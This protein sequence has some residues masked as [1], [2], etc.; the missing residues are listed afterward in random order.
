[1]QFAGKEILPFSIIPDPEEKLY[2]LYG[3]QRSILGK[4]KTMLQ[5]GK[6]KEIMS[7]G[8][9]NLQSMTKPNTLPADFLIDE[10]GQIIEA[11]YGKDFGD[12]IGL[13]KILC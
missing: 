3:L 13:N 11:Y 6:M 12:H 7:E 9:F 8:L 10:K 2:R 4:M 1:M 5:F